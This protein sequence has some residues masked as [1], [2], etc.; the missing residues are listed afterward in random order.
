MKTDRITLLQNRL[1]EN[2]KDTFALF[3]LAKEYEKINDPQRAI[4]LYLQLKD[5]DENYLGLYFHLGKSYENQ[6]LTKNALETYRQGMECAKKL[7][8][9]HALSELQNAFQNLS[10]EQDF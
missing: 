2:N 8:D 6:Q 5:V 10:L 1:A 4:A 7:G 9:F 3:A